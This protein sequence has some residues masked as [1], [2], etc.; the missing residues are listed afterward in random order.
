MRVGEAVSF[1]SELFSGVCC[2]RVSGLPTSDDG[3]FEGRK[4]QL[5][6]VVQGRF[7]RR[8]LYSELT[9]GQDFGRPLKNPPSG[10][11]VSLILTVARRISPCYNLSGPEEPRPGMTGLMLGLAQSICVS[12]LGSEPSPL[13]EPYE[14]TALLGED[15][16]SGFSARKKHFS[17]PGLWEKDAFDT[18]R[19]WTFGFWQHLMSMATFELD[20]GVTT[21]S[22]ARYIQDQPLVLSSRVGHEALYAIE[23]WNERLLKAADE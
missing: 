3:Q 13:D 17:K 12:E 19:V 2:L 7:K 8:C 14:D 21:L 23:I 4:R 18:D 16:P 22:T 1:E 15:F 20:L 9:A 5:Q 11:L 6:V 10:W